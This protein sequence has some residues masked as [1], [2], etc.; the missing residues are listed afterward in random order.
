MEIHKPKPVHSWRELLTEIGVIV[1]GVCIALAAEQLVEE[2]HWRK[3]VQDA[4]HAIATEMAENIGSA[5]VIWRRQICAERRLDEVA[6]IL[7]RARETG[8]LPPVGNI[9]R[10]TPRMWR[11]GTWDSMVAS[12]VATHFPR[13]QLAQLASTYTAI[14]LTADGVGVEGWIDLGGISGPGRR[15]DPAFEADLRRA[16]VRARAYIRAEANLASLL[17]RRMQGLQL[18]YSRQDLELIAVLRHEAMNSERGFA[19]PAGEKVLRGGFG[20]CRPIGPVPAHYGESSI[21]LGDVLT[22]ERLKALPDFGAAG[23]RE[24]RE[25]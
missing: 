8:I 11:T 3:Q 15:M 19:S 24:E 6:E 1:I 7:D 17:L 9:G 13:E 12:Q 14:R 18:P 22:D 25:R 23:A 10:L 21:P 4:R 5:I 20:I 2:I 16:L